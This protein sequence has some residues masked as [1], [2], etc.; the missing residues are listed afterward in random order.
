MSDR[1]FLIT[2][3]H[4]SAL[5]ADSEIS[6]S[7]NLAFEPIMDPIPLLWLALFDES[8]ITILETRRNFLDENEETAEESLVDI[9]VLFSTVEKAVALLDARIPLAKK[10]IPPELWCYIEEF[11]NGVRNCNCTH[12]QFD[13][14]ALWADRCRED[15]DLLKELL[16]DSLKGMDSEEE[17]VD[18]LGEAK[19]SDTFYLYGLKFLFDPFEGNADLPWCHLAEEGS[20]QPSV[21]RGNRV[22]LGGNI[23]EIVKEDP[24]DEYPIDER[25][26]LEHD[27]GLQVTERFSRVFLKVWNAFDDSVRA[28]FL[29]GWGNGFLLKIP[30]PNSGQS[31]AVHRGS[32]P[33]LGLLEHF[34]FK[35]YFTKAFGSGRGLVWCG[36]LAAELDEDVLA[37]L[38]A[39]N[40]ACALLN[41]RKQQIKNSEFPEFVQKIAGLELSVFTEWGNSN[42]ALLDDILKERMHDS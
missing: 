7:T 29:A 22:N 35:N 41:L 13:T 10:F 3:D 12:I 20:V 2:H 21:P 32:G 1:S 18:K 9:P 40:L 33:Y 8:D 38:I 15:T 37:V 5:P 6:R 14:H 27:T 16:L 24:F 39:E 42:N 17:W 34:P 28:E 36:R 26:T 23:F 4:P 30:T 25:F 11:K 31:R 19:I